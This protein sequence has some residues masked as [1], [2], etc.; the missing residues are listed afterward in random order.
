M[1]CAVTALK[2]ASSQS[3][4]IALLVFLPATLG[5]SA[6]RALYT[7]SDDD[8]G[9]AEEKSRVI[10]KTQWKCR[11]GTDATVLSWP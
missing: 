6:S 8:A 4:N 1:N 3:Q 10:R 9:G 7:A 5:T 2:I 11:T